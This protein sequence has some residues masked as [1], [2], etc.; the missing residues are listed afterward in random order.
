[1][2]PGSATA[3]QQRRRPD[4]RDRVGRRQSI[5][6][7]RHQAGQ[8]ERQQQARAD[9]RHR[10]PRAGGRQ[11]PHARRGAARR[12]PGGRR[13]RASAPRSCTR[14]PRRSR[15]T[16]AP[17]PAARASRSGRAQAIQVERAI[18]VLRERPHV[19]ERHRRIDRAH[20]GA[21][22]LDDLRAAAARSARRG[23]RPTGSDCSS[24]RYSTIR[25]FSRRLR[26]LVSRA[27]PTMA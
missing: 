15:S 5:E 19:V 4:H 12:A 6:L 16:R 7:R 27:T 9:P 10:D 26:H 22:G 24:G 14:A 11:H 25:G 23:S 1:M 13:P 17:A 21:Q 3:K 20:L 8:R 2:T 18:H